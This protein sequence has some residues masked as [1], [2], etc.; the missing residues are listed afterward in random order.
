MSL[1]ESTIKTRLHLFLSPRHI[2][3]YESTT[4]FDNHMKWD[5]LELHGIYTL[6]SRDSNNIWEPKLLI[7][8]VA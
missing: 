3:S 5:Y 6:K 7:I 4:E 1:Y 2:N 8:N